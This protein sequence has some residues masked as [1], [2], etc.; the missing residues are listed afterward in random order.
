M[1]RAVHAAAKLLIEAY[2]R[3]GGETIQVVRL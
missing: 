3:F 2:S 1:K